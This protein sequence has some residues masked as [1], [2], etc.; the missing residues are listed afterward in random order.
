[1]REAIEIHLKDSVRAA[2]ESGQP[3]LALEST[4]MTH[5]LPYP[6]NLETAQQAEQAARDAGVT[7][8]TIAVIDGRMR[9]GLS[10]REL[11]RLARLGQDADKCNR[12]DLP[13]MIRKKRTAGTTVAATLFIAHRVGIRVFATGGIGGVHQGA[14]DTFDISS[15]MHELARTPVAVVC[16]GPK[17]ILD[18]G[19]TLEYLETH[20]VPV[21]GYGT[22]MLPAFLARESEFRADFRLDTPEEIA[23]LMD[24]QWQ[25]GIEAGLVIANPIPAEHALDRKTIVQLNETAIREAIE[26][27]V[28]GKALTPYLLQRVEE[29]TDGQSL[30]ANRELMLHNARIG[31]QIAKAYAELAF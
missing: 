17:S 1:M 24:T 19:L 15:D 7:P 10:G 13:F 14:Q 26:A 25:L 30:R 28:T 23:R 22:D 3:V 20:S 29:L 18:I 4:I 6:A 2:L 12:R 9:V 21:I 16:A 27:G 31:A 5:G 8:A 11:E